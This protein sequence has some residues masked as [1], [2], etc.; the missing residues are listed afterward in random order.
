MRVLIPELTPVMTAKFLACCAGVP[1]DINWPE[2][3]DVIN[4]NYVT[5]EEDHVVR[6]IGP[7]AIVMVV[8]PHT[9]SPHTH[10]THQ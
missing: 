4:E 6:A 2:P 10:V 5:I 8:L 1:I 9:P 3:E 7:A